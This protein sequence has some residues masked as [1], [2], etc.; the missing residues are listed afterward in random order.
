MKTYIM[1]SATG[2]PSTFTGSPS[3]VVD[4]MTKNTQMVFKTREDFRR[5][6]AQLACDWTGS[7]VRFT[8]DDELV[9]DLIEVG[10][11]KEKK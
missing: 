9:E 2:A 10:F 5:S 3:E 8:T 11:L 4:Q 6:Y 1:Q 7:P